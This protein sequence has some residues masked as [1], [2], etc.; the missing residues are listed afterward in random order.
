MILFLLPDIGARQ[1]RNKSDFLY[2]LQSIKTHA[3][4]ARPHS[5]AQFLTVLGNQSGACAIH[6][7]DAYRSAEPRSPNLVVPRVSAA[8]DERV[9]ASNRWW[10]NYRPRWRWARLMPSTTK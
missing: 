1:S 10:T 6:S 4:R 8:N 9:R 2:I 5:V 3:I 7:C